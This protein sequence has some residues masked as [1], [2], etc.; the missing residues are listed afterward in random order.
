[1]K[2][3]L[4]GLLLLAVSGCGGPP[5]KSETTQPQFP[6]TEQS[7]LK[8]S[9]Q[10]KY[11][12]QGLEY[13]KAGKLAA[14]IKSFDEAIKQSPKDLRGYVV[15]GQTYLRVKDYSRAIDTFTA[16]TRVAPD[17]GDIYFFLAV[18]QNMA[19]NKEQAVINAQKSAEVFR[20]KND[21][22]NFRKSVL[23]LQSLMQNAPPK[24]G[25]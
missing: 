13:L 10:T 20:Q 8:P 19:G 3:F 9:P 18:S 16:A 7:A 21:Q 22:V 12:D 6:E 14:A 15:L 1:M 5:P 11:V 23:F 4:A 2:K 17:Q 24:A 25:E